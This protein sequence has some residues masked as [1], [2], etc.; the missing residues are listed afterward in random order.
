[1]N[2]SSLAQLPPAALGAILFVEMLVLWAA[3]R[4]LA[5]AFIQA[6]RWP[7]LWMPLVAPGTVLHECAHAGMALV[8]RVR[9]HAFQPFRPE[10]QPDGGYRFGYVRLAS[11]DPLRNALVAIAPLFLVP[12]FLA[13]VNAYAF[14]SL[15]PA[16]R[17][18]LELSPGWLAAWLVLVGL[19]SR[20]AFPSP[21]DQVGLIGGGLVLL[22]IGGAGWGLLQAGGPSMLHDG[23]ASLA[24]L[25]LLPAAINALLLG[26]TRLL[27]R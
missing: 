18:V 26:F 20:A 10:R 3:Q 9:I 21:G 2:A 1:M 4:R 14:G 13:S 25:L 23:L 6:A 8:L 27:R 5:G 22:A 7:V 15:F 16:P 17:D 12:A 11:V 24:G 19:G